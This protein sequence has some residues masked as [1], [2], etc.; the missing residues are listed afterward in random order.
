MRVF[1]VMALRKLPLLLVTPRRSVWRTVRAARVRPAGLIPSCLRSGVRSIC[2]QSFS[3]AFVFY[4]TSD[5]KMC[6]TSLISRYLHRAFHS[7]KF[8]FYPTHHEI[9]DTLLCEVRHSDRALIKSLSC[10]GAR[11]CWR[12]NQTPMG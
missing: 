11:P 2:V 4:C 5:A 10:R 12:L 8:P 1:V 3:P 9:L 7:S 6:F